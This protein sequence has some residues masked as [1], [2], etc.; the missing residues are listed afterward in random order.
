MLGFKTP[1]VRG[2]RPAIVALVAEACAALV[3]L[4]VVRVHF[5]MTGTD[6]SLW[7]K[8]A[9]A[10]AVAGSIGYLSRASL[11]WVILLAALPALLVGTLSLDLPGWIPVTILAVL[12][13][14]LR[15]SFGER[16]PLYLSN[17][18]TL[19]K[20]APLIPADRPIRFVDLG[21][22]LGDVPISLA[23]H[24]THPDSR[25]VGVENAPIPY[26]LAWIAA[27]RRRDPRIQVIWRSL[28]HTQLQDFD[29]VYAFLSPQPMPDLFAKA[30]AEMAPESLFISNSFTVPDHPPEQTIPIDS[31][32]ATALMIWKPGKR[33]NRAAIE[34]E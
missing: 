2:Y 19:G 10:G 29:C 24:N 1:S 22:G 20:L 9:L 32:R 8:L 17:R 23:R 34:Q 4:G 5:A 28:W 25:F 27:W 11:S 21:C 3:T 31:G 26:L 15:N 12:V 30:Q 18:E 13:L 16:V 33:D 14:V 6:L 7:V